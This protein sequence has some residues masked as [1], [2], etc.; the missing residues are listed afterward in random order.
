MS[1]L[2]DIK[3]KAEDASDNPQFQKAE[4]YAKEHNIPVDKAEELLNKGD[5]EGD[6]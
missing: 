4:D 3:D 6:K 5:N 1:L 2:D